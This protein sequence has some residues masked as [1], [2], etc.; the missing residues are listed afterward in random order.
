MRVREDKDDVKKYRVSI[1]YRDIL[2]LCLLFSLVSLGFFLF[3]IF[4]GYAE[5]DASAYFILTVHLV[6]I[7]CFI[8]SMFLEIP[9]YK[10]SVSRTGITMYE[11]RHT[12]KFSWDDFVDYGTTV[13]DFSPS[14]PNTTF[15]IY[16][17]KRCLRDVE[18]CDFL[19]KIG[20]KRDY[21]AYFQYSAKTYDEVKQYFPAE[22]R[23]QL[24]WEL[25]PW[26]ENM[27]LTEKIRNR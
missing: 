21:I 17:A 7:I 10:F 6:T 23:E 16:F 14:A 9:S 15:W 5:A 27:T 11:P 22:W 3:L 19:R 26:I 20:R 18:K 1:F 12:Y 24:D 2:I 13:L 8:L 25:A 4:G